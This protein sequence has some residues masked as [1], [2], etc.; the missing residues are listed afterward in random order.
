M[1]IVAKFASFREKK[2]EEKQKVFMESI[3]SSAVTEIKEGTHF[4]TPTNGRGAG[5]ISKTQFNAT[6]RRVE[7]LENDPSGGLAYIPL[8]A[9]GTKT[10][11]GDD[12]I[13]GINIIGVDAPG[14]VTIQLPQTL[15]TGTIV[16]IKD[17]SLSAATNNITVE[18]YLEV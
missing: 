7:A 13:F 15:T 9:T 5:G 6:V 1:S 3:V 10:Y 4:T 12:F 16:K 11:I 2:K 8:T 14:A 18:T 17:E